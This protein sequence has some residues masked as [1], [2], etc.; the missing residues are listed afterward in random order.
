MCYIL[1]FAWGQKIVD[2]FFLKKHLIIQLFEEFVKLYTDIPK[3]TFEVKKYFAKSSLWDRNLWNIVIGSSRKTFGNLFFAKN[4]KTRVF[5]PISEE[6]SQFLNH[7]PKRSTTGNCR[8]TIKRPHYINCNFLLAF[9]KFSGQFLLNL[10][11]EIFSS[12]ADIFS[13][14]CPLSKSP[15]FEFSHFCRVKIKKF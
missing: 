9:R 14:F 3:K 4:L 1:H 7:F 5:S 10:K 15:S 8:S 12:F 6:I 13:N 2:T 11:N